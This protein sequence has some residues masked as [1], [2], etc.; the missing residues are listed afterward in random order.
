VRKAEVFLYAARYGRADERDRFLERARYFFDESMTTLAASATRTL[1]RPMVL[2]LSNGFMV[3]GFDPARAAWAAG[4]AAAGEWQE[5]FAP[6]VSFV[7]QKTAAKKRLVGAAAVFVAVLV[8][9]LITFF[10]Y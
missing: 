1:A 10:R 6:A 8:L 7:R 5:S 4:A 3:A 9:A 2:L